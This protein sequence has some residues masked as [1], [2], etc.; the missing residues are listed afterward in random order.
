MSTVRQ[1]VIDAP[2]RRNALSRRVLEALLAELTTLDGDVVGVVLSGRGDA[3]SSGADFADLTGTSADL[4]YD[5]AVAAVTRTIR[6]L[7]VVVIA[8]LEGPCIGAAADL[9]LSCDVRVAAEGSF[10]QV[11]AV[12]L[13][14]LY[15][16]E[17]VDRL[18]RSFPRDTI[19]RLLL[20]GERFGH[21]EALQAGLVSHVV[22][23]GDAV[24][25]ATDLLQQAT[26]DHL[27]AIAATKALLNAQET[28]TVDTAL[29][30]EHR[31]ALLDSPG[32]QAAVEKAKRVH[33]EK[34]S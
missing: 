30:E 29:W 13:G 25:R 15:N 10:L 28:G 4:E 1:V 34:E 26:T 6:E 19:R 9:A 33:T 3:F 12:R 7:P 27:A 21:D 18:R 20:L 16:P 5:G 23:R 8:A 11:P 32:R 31:R 14:I 22:P 17:S 2:G 24:H